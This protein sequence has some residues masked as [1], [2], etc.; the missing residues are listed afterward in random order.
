MSQ[1]NTIPN[2]ALD[3]N[4]TSPGNFR[5]SRISSD[6]MN[7]IVPVKRKTRAKTTR[8]NVNTIKNIVKLLNVEKD[9][10]II[11]NQKD[12]TYSEVKKLLTNPKKQEKDDNK[13]RTDFFMRF[14]NVPSLV[15]KRVRTD[16]KTED[17]ITLTKALSYISAPINNVIYK[18]HND[19]DVD[20][21]NNFF[22]ERENYGLKAAYLDVESE[23]MEI[24]PEIKASIEEDPSLNFIIL[25][26]APKIPHAIIVVIA[27]GK[28]YSIGYGFSGILPNEDLI[29]TK[30]RDYGQKNSLAFK[31]SH[32]A[33]VLNGALYTADYLLPNDNQI[34]IPIWIDI[35]N[36]KHIKR[37]EAE[38]KKT[39]V[40]QF[41]RE[42]IDH[43]ILILE[44]SKY[45]E[46]ASINPINKGFEN[47]L[48]WGQSVLG[49]KKRLCV[50]NNPN[51]CPNYIKAKE[52]DKFINVYK[53]N[54]NTENVIKEIQNR[55]MTDLKPE[56]SVMK[57]ILYKGGGNKSKKNKKHKFPLLK[58]KE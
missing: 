51:Q 38:L 50:F 1:F 6:N 18:Y 42:N 31:M 17:G 49:L 48:L 40:I 43:R 20:T 9:K 4:N 19:S 53:N 47:C 23:L 39:K 11:K 45:S 57:S 3:F 28:M 12:F 8:R 24:R 10:S 7:R 21:M 33:D 30:M 15:N 58:N 54:E 5:N 13:I 44:N 34:F 29:K 22:E 41:R 37:I 14:Q 56:L 35:L 46:S 16:G 2:R 25:A 55:I 26:V 52:W 36:D 32:F 27:N